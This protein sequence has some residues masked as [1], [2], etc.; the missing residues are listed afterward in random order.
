MTAEAAK[1]DVNPKVYRALLGRTLP[2]VIHSE[3]Q[4]ERYLEILTGF[5]SREELSPGRAGTCRPSHGSDREVRGGA[6]P[7]ESIDARHYAAVSD[8]PHGL[9]QKGR[10]G[11]FGTESATSSGIGRETRVFKG[12]YDFLR[13]RN[14][15]PRVVRIRLTFVIRYD[16]P[17]KVFNS[18]R[19]CE[20][21]P[22]VAS[23]ADTGRPCSSKAGPRHS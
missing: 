22:V 3:E 12:A 1:T 18:G 14:G 5:D 10:L 13:S 17:Y 16:K 19:Y 4:N 6:L 11:L 2:T 15:S 20:Q 7:S 21:S 23:R 9:K 8:G